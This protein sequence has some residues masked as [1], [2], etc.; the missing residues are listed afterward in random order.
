MVSAYGLL[1]M[2]GSTECQRWEKKVVPSGGRP[3]ETA[4]TTA[5]QLSRFENTYGWFKKNNKR[6]GSFSQ[7]SSM[8]YFFKTVAG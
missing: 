5:I 8:K 3:T 6:C 2:P 1:L 4:E 7:L